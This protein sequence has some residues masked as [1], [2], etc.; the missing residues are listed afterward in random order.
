MKPPSNVKNLPA[1]PDKFWQ[2]LNLRIKAPSKKPEPTPGET[3]ALE[4][5]PPPWLKRRDK[6]VFRDLTKVITDLSI[7]DP[8]GHVALGMLADG[9]DDY[10]KEV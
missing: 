2:G 1:P 6:K 10:L 9:I 4:V 5:K 7:L 8:A 3:A